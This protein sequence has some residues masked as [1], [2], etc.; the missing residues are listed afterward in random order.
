MENSLIFSILLSL[1]FK[2]NSQVITQS[3]KGNN[4]DTLALI[5]YKNILSEEKVRILDSIYVCYSNILNKMPIPNYKYDEQKAGTWTPDSF[6]VNSKNWL[7]HAGYVTNTSDTI[8]SVVRNFYCHYGPKPD[9]TLVFHIVYIDYKTNK[10]LMLA[11]KYN[12]YEAEILFFQDEKTF[13]ITKSYLDLH[14]SK[15]PLTKPSLSVYYKD[16]KAAFAYFIGDF[17]HSVALE[18]TNGA[19]GVADYF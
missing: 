17:R 14:N 2:A 12:E 7:F 1:V 8:G 16:Y 10:I 13:I 3:V 6:R 5:F 19:Y 18:V 11:N 4:T 9:Y 15:N